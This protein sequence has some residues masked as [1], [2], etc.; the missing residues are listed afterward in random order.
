MHVV[1]SPYVCHP[2]TLD[3]PMT[4]SLVQVI[5]MGA[6]MSGHNWLLEER[7]KKKRKIQTLCSWTAGPLTLTWIM[8]SVEVSRS[9]AADEAR[10]FP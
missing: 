1:K 3:S 6:V 10:D 9:T 4:V 7:R 8:L 5:A 2:F